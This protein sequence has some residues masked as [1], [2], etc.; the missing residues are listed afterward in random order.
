MDIR[1]LRSTGSWACVLF[2]FALSFVHTRQLSL[3]SVLVLI[4]V[5][6]PGNAGVLALEYVAAQDWYYMPP[7][8]KSEQRSCLLDGPVWIMLSCACRYGKCDCGPASIGQ[9]R[10]LARAGTQ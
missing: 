2:V 4:P 3:S 6:W 5:S 9:L 7:C 1:I 8:A 10:Y